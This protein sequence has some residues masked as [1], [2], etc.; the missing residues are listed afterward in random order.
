MLAASPTLVP[1]R[2]AQTASPRRAGHAACISLR[3]SGM[4]PDPSYVAVII[5]IR[6]H[7]LEPLRL[8]LVL[9]LVLWEVMRSARATSADALKG[10]F[11][12]KLVFGIH[13]YPR[14]GSSLTSL[15]MS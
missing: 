10:S 3:A 14:M 5:I 2:A 15:S 1:P 6:R 11:T 13:G 9:V 7:R 12:V 8:T 4:I